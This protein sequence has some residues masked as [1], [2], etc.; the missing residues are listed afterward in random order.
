MDC[1]RLARALNGTRSD[2]YRYAV[3]RA[4]SDLPDEGGDI[5]DVEYL[6]VMHRAT[7]V[8][9]MLEQMAGK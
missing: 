6:A 2:R 8:F 5:T 1:E 4:V 7:A 3:D 9:Q